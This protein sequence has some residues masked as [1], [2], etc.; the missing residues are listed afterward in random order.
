[1]KEPFALFS[2]II[3]LTLASESVKSVRI[4]IIFK[5]NNFEGVWNDLESKSRVQRQ[6]VKKYL[7]LTLVSMSKS[8]QREPSNRSLSVLSY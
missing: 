7:R 5:E 2:N 8:T 3:A 1:M 6:S 4:T